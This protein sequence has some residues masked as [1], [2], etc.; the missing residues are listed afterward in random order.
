MA[1]DPFPD[2]L[3]GRLHAPQG[4]KGLT[5]SRRFTKPLMQLGSLASR[6]LVTAFYT[7]P[8]LTPISVAEGRQIVAERFS[9]PAEIRNARRRRREDTAPLAAAAASPA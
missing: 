7:Y 8:E 4:T 6:S 1:A 2:A 9:I 5:G 3:D